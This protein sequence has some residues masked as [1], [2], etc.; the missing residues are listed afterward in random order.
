MSVS[1][2]KRSSL[3]QYIFSLL[4]PSSKMEFSFI[5]LVSCCT[6]L[7]G[8]YA[9]SL[10]ASEVAEEVIEELAQTIT[11][12]KLKSASDV[13]KDVPAKVIW[14]VAAT[15]EDSRPRMG[16]RASNLLS[17]SDRP[18]GKRSFGEKDA[19]FVSRG[20]S[21]V[22]GKDDDYASSVG[23]ASDAPRPRVGK[24]ASNWILLSA[25]DRPRGKRSKS[26]RPHVGDTAFLNYGPSIA[27]ANDDF[28]LP[29]G[30]TSHSSRPRVV[31]R[32]SEIEDDDFF[33][34]LEEVSKSSGSKLDIGTTN[35]ELSLAVGNKMERESEGQLLD[36]YSIV[37]IKTAP[38]NGHLIQNDIN[39]NTF[40]N[41]KGKMNKLGEI[42]SRSRKDIE[43]GAVKPMGPRGGKRESLAP[44]GGKR[45]SLKPCSRGGKRMIS[46]PRGGK[47][48]AT[49]ALY[50]YCGNGV[51]KKDETNK[52]VAGKRF[53]S[54]Q[55]RGSDDF[56]PRPRV[57]K[58]SEREIAPRPRAGK[59]AIELAL[60]KDQ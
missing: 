16:K 34:S 24:R 44:R 53:A 51:V 56:A 48:D 42:L 43:S 32:A 58:R 18:R 59:R 60:L 7:F 57:G 54:S 27:S 55:F 25:Y 37:D 1:L 17:M 4:R 45:E 35:E 21:I 2:F 52:S 14:E 15:S 30:A 47:K 12:F 3:I 33:N 13:L 6:M 5:V 26:G 38:Y 9:A 28:A 11:H 50:W 8:S 36:Y 22:S 20:P 19:T 31:K 10:N 41:N 40:D 49:D 23:A 46:K 39:D 29:V